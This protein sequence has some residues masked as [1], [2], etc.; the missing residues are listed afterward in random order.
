MCPSISD[1]EHSTTTKEKMAF[2]YDL[3]TN[4]QRIREDSKAD[5]EAQDSEIA[6]LG[7]KIFKGSLPR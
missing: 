6:S 7:S 3:Q 2:Y 5:H 1:K 4:D